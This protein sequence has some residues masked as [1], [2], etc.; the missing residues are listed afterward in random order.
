MGMAAD[1]K[2][3]LVTEA[4]FLCFMPVRPD[5]V[6]LGN[7]YLLFGL[8]ATWIAGL[9]R[10]WDH[11]KALWW[12]YAG[13]GSL[14]YIGILAGILWLLYWP[15]RPKNWSYISV[16]TFVGMTSPPAILYAIP[17]ERFMSMPVAQGLNVAFLLVVAAWRVILLVLFLLR[18]AKL[19]PARVLLAVPLPLAL[20]VVALTILNLEHVV[21]DLMAG[22]RPEEQSPGD[23]AYH[24]LF[25]ISVLSFYA[26]PILIAVYIFMVLDAWGQY[27]SEIAAASFSAVEGDVSEADRDGLVDGGGER[28]EIP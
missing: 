27:K 11:P 28:H 25:L 4:K 24:F 10:Y 13:L 19:S 18:S 2:E 14:A 16:L 6:R 7:H 12:Q 8:L 22:I 5:M 15:L 26:S 3:V 9:G 20:I 17:V 1:C 23:G 21:F